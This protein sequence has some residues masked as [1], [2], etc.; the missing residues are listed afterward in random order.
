M[1]N[2]VRARRYD[3]FVSQIKIIV[4]AETIIEL[5]IIH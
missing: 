4:Y 1:S 2:S 3:V 5:N